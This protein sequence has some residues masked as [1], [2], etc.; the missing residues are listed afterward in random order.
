MPKAQETIVEPHGLARGAPFLGSCPC[1][2]ARWNL[3]RMDVKR[4]GIVV[5]EKA[6]NTKHGN[7]KQVDETI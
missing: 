5:A 2:V 1:T 7:R 6:R 4:L 3:K